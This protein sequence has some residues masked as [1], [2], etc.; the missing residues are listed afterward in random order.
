MAEDEGEKTEAAPAGEAGNGEEQVAVVPPVTHVTPWQW[1]AIVLLGLAAVGMYIVWPYFVANDHQVLQ[2]AEHYIEKAEIGFERAHREDSF[3]RSQRIN[4]FQDVAWNYEAALRAGF[5]PDCDDEFR[6]GYVHFRLA[7]DK[8]GGAVEGFIQPVRSF[9]QALHLWNVGADVSQ[10][11][12]RYMLGLSYLYIKNP[13]EAIKQFDFLRR[14]KWQL[15]SY[16]RSLAHRPDRQADPP[17][18]D[19]STDPYH[20]R[21]R[22]LMGVDLLLGESYYSEGRL[23]E[24][25]ATLVDYLEST[26]TPAVERTL[27]EHTVEPDNE[28][29]FQALDLLGKI[30]W[31]LARESYVA[32]KRARAGRAGEETL[33]KQLVGWRELLTKG[34]QYLLELQT[35]DYQIYD[36]ANARL[37]LAEIHYRLGERDQVLKLAQGYQHPGRTERESMNLWSLMAMLDS[38]PN[39]PVG[40]ALAAVANAGDTVQDGVRLAALVLLGQTQSR[41]GE[42]DLPLGELIEPMPRHSGSPREVGAYVQATSEFDE[43]LFDRNPFIDK[44][45][46]IDHVLAR[47]LAARE[48]SD[49]STAIRL[50]KYLLKYFSIPQAQTLHQIGFLKRVYARELVAKA[51]LDDAAREAFRD[52]AIFYLKALEVSFDGEPFANAHFEAAESYFEGHHF[53]RAYEH[54]GLFLDTRLDDT[55]ESKA[56]HKRGLSALHRDRETRFDD[57]VREFTAN[58]SRGVRPIDDNIP[59][60]RNLLDQGIESTT[61]ASDILRDK[62]VLRPQDWYRDEDKVDSVLRDVN[63]ASRDLWAYQS[64][65][66]LGNAFYAQHL[67]PQAERIYNAI[68][69]D[70]RFSPDAEIWRKAAYQRGLLSYDRAY[71][72]AVDPEIKVASWPAAIGRMEELLLRYDVRLLNSRHTDESDGQTVKD[73]K[74][75]VFLKE[76]R[77]ANARVKHLLASAYLKHQKPDLSVMHAGELLDPVESDRYTLDETER[78]KTHAL[79]GDGLFRLQKY[80]EAYEQYRIAHDHYLDSFERPFYSLNMADCLVRMGQ[81]PRA[82]IK[83]KQTR[84]E[85]EE[86][87]DD[88]RPVLELE[89]EK[90]DKAYWIAYVSN[91]IR[92]L[93]EGT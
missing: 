5:E 29:R 48:A 93:E 9:K 39:L 40:P 30:Y 1:T 73:V 19:L 38:D 51:G 78:R 16:H 4:T 41:R 82:L 2:P 42:V 53:S 28:A 13:T 61:E 72:E 25:A 86:L 7:I 83:L 24:A 20:M 84:W 21:M 89:K 92:R 76:I 47:A 57:A 26:R 62:T 36:T 70:R 91:K 79:L 90:L 11:K 17:P 67:Y 37:R 3:P 71:E 45:T 77:T 22:D 44:K 85:F 65:L 18:L 35:P 68:M 23:S 56:R 52:S 59:L 32:L 31:E 66:E 46:L 27:G 75:K 64:F 88:S 50:Y 58:I 60:P 8:Y 63:I 14:D 80:A 34:R 15:L 54:Y 87:F 10:E 74:E 55:R 69:N 12:I 81:T 6:R 49:E 43:T 33:E